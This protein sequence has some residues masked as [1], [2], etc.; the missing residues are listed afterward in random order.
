MIKSTKSF[1]LT[2]SYFKIQLLYLSAESFFISSRLLILFQVSNEFCFFV[3]I[4]DTFFSFLYFFIFSL[5]M[6]DQRNENNVVLLSIF[7]YFI[8]FLFLF[9]SFYLLI[10]VR[11]IK[12]VW[13][14]RRVETKYHDA[15]VETIR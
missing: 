14:C 12:C 1:L 6:A 3:L 8:L 10:Q 11:T 4:E 5:L 2:A 7:L 9:V 15:T 13:K